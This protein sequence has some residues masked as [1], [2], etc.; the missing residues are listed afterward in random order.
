MKK[1]N[2]VNESTTA[3]SITHGLLLEDFKQNLFNLIT[4]HALDIQ[5][6]AIV[7]DYI[8]IQIQNTAIQ[9]TQKEL[10]NYKNAQKDTLEQHNEIVNSKT[11]ETSE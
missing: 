3:P 11:S 2:I 8:N 6:K 9:Q 4:Q 1:E 7:L 5:S 10:E